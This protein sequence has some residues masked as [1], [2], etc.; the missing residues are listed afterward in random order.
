MS[1]AYHFACLACC[2]RLVLSAYPSKPH[3]ASMLGAIER[4]TG[5]PGRERILECVGQEL[6]KRRSLA[7]KSGTA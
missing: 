4:Y 1:G 2:T 6:T 3:A 7:P 5:N